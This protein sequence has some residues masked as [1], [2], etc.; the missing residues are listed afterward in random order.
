MAIHVEAP[1]P[2]TVLQIMVNVG[3]EVK[4]DTELLI[5]EAM[6]MENPIAAPSDGRIAEIKVK[7]QDQVKTNQILIVLE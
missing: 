2:G 7:E 3:D 1:F 6:K 5:I 4:E